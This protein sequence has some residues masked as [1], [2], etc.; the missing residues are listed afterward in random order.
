MRKLFS[1]LNVVIPMLAAVIAA[2]IYVSDIQNKV[3]EVKAYQIAAHVAFRDSFPRTEGMLLKKDIDYIKEMLMRM[4]NKLNVILG[5]E[6]ELNDEVKVE[7]MD[8]F[9]SH[10]KFSPPKENCKRHHVAG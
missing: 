2:T 7:K 4:D 8:A 6:E 1:D 3:S 5:L 9:V 10:C